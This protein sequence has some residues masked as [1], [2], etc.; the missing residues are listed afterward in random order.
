VTSLL[1]LRLIIIFY[2]TTKKNDDDDGINITYSSITKDLYII[3]NKYF[4]FLINSVLAV[5]GGKRYRTTNKN[6]F[7]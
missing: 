6:A 1:L 2:S 7:A 4:F 3:I 5:E